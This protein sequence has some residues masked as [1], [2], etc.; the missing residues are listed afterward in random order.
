MHKIYTIEYDPRLVATARETFEK[1]GFD[2]R[3]HLIEGR[4]EDA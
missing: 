3:M 4:A 2:D 1:Y